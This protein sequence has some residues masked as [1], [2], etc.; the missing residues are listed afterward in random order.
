MLRTDDVGQ[1][2]R[3]NLSPRQPTSPGQP[4]RQTPAPA[5]LQ[6]FRVEPFLISAILCL[7]GVGVYMWPRV[8]GVRLAY[9]LQDAEHRLQDLMRER[10]RL[11]VEL[12]ALADPQRVYQVATEQLG[13]VAPKHD[14]VFILLGES[15]SR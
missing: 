2:P 8:Q 4:P 10:D 14:Q 5:L 7:L 9:R 12:A 1:A 3:P 15:K 6:R 11:R 13:M